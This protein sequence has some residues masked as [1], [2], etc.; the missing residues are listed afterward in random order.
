MK[1]FLI[2]IEG[3]KGSEKQALSAKESCEG[4][5]F[6]IELTPG[7]TPKTLNQYEQ[8]PEIDKSR[9]LDFKKSNQKTYLTKMSC[10]LNHIQVWKKC[11]ELNEPVAFIEHDSFN[12]RAWDNQD[13]QDILILNIDAAFKQP[14]FSH[15]SNKLKPQ[16]GL[17]MYNKSPFVYNRENVFKGG[18]LIPGTGAYAIKPHAAK[19]LL[20]SVEK[21]GW[22]Q[23][24]YF[25]NTSHV[26]LEYIMPEY[27]IFKHSN[28]NT[29]HGF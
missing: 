13:W 1:A 16:S 8:Y 18:L 17:N 21:Y 29:S 14:V 27:F 26:T 7:I 6:N 25:I 23:S 22:E 3:H 15:V 20:S 28:L 10:F 19:K 12:V 4:S 5:G 9:A 11:I 24:D 2:Y